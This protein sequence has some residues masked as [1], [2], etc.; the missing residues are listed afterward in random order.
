MD[1]KRRL[2]FAFKV[3]TT[4]CCLIGVLS[5]LFHTTCLASVLSFYTT[6]SNLLV[7]VFYIGY[8]IAR[9]INSKVE[10]T[11]TY[12]LIKGLVVMAI[13][14]T[15]I[16]YTIS[17][18]PNDFFMDVKTASSDIF[19]LSNILVHFVTPIMVIL[20]YFLFDEKGYYKKYYA[21]IWIIFPALYPVYVFVYS[22]LGGRFFSI[23]GSEKYAYFFLDVDKIGVIGVTSYLLLFVACYLALSF[24]VIKIDRGLGRRK[25]N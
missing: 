19:R 18:Q 15:F 25:N 2:S 10:K 5:N 4:V 16:V 21:F 24:L 6:Q 3:A 14:L 17:L 20:D 7:L 8:F 22:H 11:N 9:K 12:H 23:G 1:S 13:A